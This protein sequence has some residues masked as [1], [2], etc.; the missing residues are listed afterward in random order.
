MEGTLESRRIPMETRESFGMTVNLHFGL[1][2]KNTGDYANLYC[3]NETTGLFEYLGSYQVNKDGQ[4]MF[5]IEEGADYLLTVTV[6]KPDE[7]IAV[8]GRNYYTVRLGD[9]L[10]RIASR[11]KISLARIMALNP[12]I[13]NADRIRPGQRIRIR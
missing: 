7:E 2:T 4:A 5:G 3:Y 9:T 8:R 6:E 10:L 11:N 13:K 12:D 1:G